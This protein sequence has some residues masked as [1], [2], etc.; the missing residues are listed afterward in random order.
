MKHSSLYYSTWPSS[1]AYE[2]CGAGIIIPIF[3][4]EETEAQEG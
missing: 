2:I 4:D 3:T 1:Q